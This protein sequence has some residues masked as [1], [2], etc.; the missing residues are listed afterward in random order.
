MKTKLELEQEIERLNGI[1]REQSKALGKMTN[2]IGVTISLPAWAHGANSGSAPYIKP[3]GSND[4]V[5]RHKVLPIITKALTKQGIEFGHELGAFG[6][7]SLDLHEGHYGCEK[8]CVVPELIADILIEFMNAAAD[9]AR[10]AHAQGIR[11]G[12]SLLK[13][14]ANGTIT[15]S[16][17][18]DQIAQEQACDVQ[19]HNRYR[20]RRHKENR[21]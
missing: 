14:L 6:G 10:E 11:E 5:W 2:K 3:D 16:S 18:E 20:K 13:Q 15:A 8:S 7:S 1:V 19:A 17:Y 4:D 9:F 12:T 21:K